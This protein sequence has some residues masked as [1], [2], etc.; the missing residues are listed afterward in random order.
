[1][2]YIGELRATTHTSVRPFF[3]AYLDAGFLFLG[4]DAVELRVGSAKQVLPGIDT[5]TD[6]CVADGHPQQIWNL[7]TRELVAD[8]RT[9]TH[10]VLLRRRLLKHHELIAAITCD[11]AA[12][13]RS[14]LF[15]RSRYDLEGMVAL[16]MSIVIVNLLKA[17]GVHH[18]QIHIF[19]L[20]HI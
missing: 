1:M 13:R 16:H 10:D 3:L 19:C 6:P 8:C 15:E 17:V 2:E 7:G 5:I 18:E 11:K 14:D 12:R 9:Q 20:T 4:L